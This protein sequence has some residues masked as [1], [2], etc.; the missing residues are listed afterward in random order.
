MRRAILHASC[1]SHELR[2]NWQ[3]VRRQ[4][5]GFLGSHFVHARHLKHDAAGLHHRNPLFRSAFTFAHAGFR[6][7]LG[8][9][10]VRENPDPKLSATLDEA[11]NGHTRSFDLAVGNP[12]T[13][14]RFQTVLAKCQIAA[15]PGFASAPPAHLLSV[16]HLLGHQHRYVLASLISFNCRT[17]V[18]NELRYRNDLTLFLHFRSA[19]WN[20]FAL[21]YPALHANHSVSGIRAR[22]AEV[23]IGAKRLQRQAA[24][25]IP[26]FT[27][28]FRAIQATRYANLDAFATKTQCG[29]NRFA[30]SAAESYALLELQRD[31]FGHQL[32]IEIRAMYFLDVDMHFALGA[33]FHVLLE[34]V[35]LRAFTAD[36]NARSRGVNTHHQLIGGTLDINGADARAL[37]L[38]FQLGAQLH[39]FVQQLGI[40]AIS[41]PA[42]LPRLVVAQSKSVRVCLLSHSYPLRPKTRA[43]SRATTL[44]LL[45]LFR[46]RAL[47]AGQCFTNPASRAAYTFLRFGFRFNGGDPF[48]CGD[49]VLRYA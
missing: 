21:I 18:R 3:L 30:H 4:R 41:V 17:R 42:G 47:F 22:H 14:K 44:F 35:D 10:L 2:R 33:L 43:T 45:A 5:H 19:L 11:R 49:V 29:V 8:E 32:S 39:V 37:Q 15:A 6:R 12:R 38:L 13:L 20:V 28:D 23:D 40:V 27:R 24:L 34:L 48:C 7:L 31:G 46:V 9:G 26:F 36:D 16:L 25:Q 1:A